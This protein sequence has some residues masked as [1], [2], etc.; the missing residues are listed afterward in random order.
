[1]IHYRG[2]IPWSELSDE[3]KWDYI[4]RERNTRLSASDW[5]QLPDAALT[6]E[7]KAAWQERRQSLRDVPQ[8]FADPNDVVLPVAPGV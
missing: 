3:I 5:T 6:I 4:K 7:E 2:D 8:V 1:M